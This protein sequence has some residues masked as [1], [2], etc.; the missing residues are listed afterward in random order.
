MKPL[1]QNF[2]PEL[3]EKI[4]KAGRPK[5]FGEEEQIFAEGDEA[6]F[7]PIV[8]SGSVKMVRFPEV[9]KEVI[10][11]IFQDGEIFAI[12][13]A[14]D[15][16][17]YPATAIAVTKTKLL[18]LQRPDFLILM[19]ESSEFSAL[20]MS[21]MCGLL[22]DMNSTVQILATPSSEQRVGAVIMN[23]ANKEDAD[24][25]VKISLRR[26]DIAEMSGVTTETA[27]RCVR[28]LADRGL[29]QIVR[30][31]IILTQ[32]APLKKFLQQKI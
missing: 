20:I 28:K 25:P 10:I 4:I 26:Q 29:I 19:E 30:G 31:K 7:L 27:I 32:I 12:P 21:R 16:K 15:G 2:S 6:R 1:L 14:L 17:K 18:K 22:R 5:D 9:G 8:L 3:Y 23:L 24:E 11:G 13:P